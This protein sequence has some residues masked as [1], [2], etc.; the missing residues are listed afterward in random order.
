MPKDIGGTNGMHMSSGKNP[1][2]GGGGKTPRPKTAR[3]V[4]VGNNPGGEGHMVSA[5][6][7]MKQKRNLTG[8]GK[9]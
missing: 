9:A 6:S 7:A 2:T 3:T 8:P 5:N 4:G 1:F